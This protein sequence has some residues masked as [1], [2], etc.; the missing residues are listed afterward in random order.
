MLSG[1]ELPGVA[2][3]SELSFLSSMKPCPPHICQELKR[4]HGLPCNPGVMS[5]PRVA[6]ACLDQ[7]P[8]AFCTPK[9][10]NPTCLPHFAAAGPQ[11]SGSGELIPAKGHCGLWVGEPAYSGCH[12]LV[13]SCLSRPPILDGGFLA[14][15]QA[16][17]L[18]AAA[19]ALPVFMVI[20]RLHWRGCSCPHKSQNGE[21]APLT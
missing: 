14:H 20:T 2:G 12:L 1:W 18:E 10:L 6:S 17:V 8:R 21:L 7:P 16:S 3:D 11:K 19:C 13:C 15:T 4:Y 5:L 9:P